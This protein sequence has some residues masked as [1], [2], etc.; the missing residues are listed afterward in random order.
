LLSELKAGSE[1]VEFLNKKQK[2]LIKKH[3][4]G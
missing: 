3:F 1:R 2:E 4:N